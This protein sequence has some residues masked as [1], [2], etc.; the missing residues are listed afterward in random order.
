MITSRPCCARNA[1]CRCG[2]SSTPGR[3]ECRYTLPAPRSSVADACNQWCGLIA[4]NHE[5]SMAAATRA[6]PAASMNG[7]L[8]HLAMFVAVDYS[9]ALRSTSVL[10][11]SAQTWQ[12]PIEIPQRCPSRTFGITCRF[13]PWL[14]SMRC[15]R[16]PKVF[17]REN[18]RLSS[19]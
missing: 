5:S 18:H 4:T 13:V 8:L 16:R 19:R 2:F 17:K 1:H 9:L 11:T 7:E 3:A 14:S 15:H 10:D 12:S 6:T